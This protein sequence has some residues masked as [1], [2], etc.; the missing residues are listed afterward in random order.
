MGDS[1]E[2]SPRKRRRPSRL[3]FAAGALLSVVFAFFAALYGAEPRGLNP[4]IF[5][6]YQRIMPRDWSPDVP[7]RIA[8]IDSESIARYGQWPWPRTYFAEMVSR[9][10]ELGAAVIVFDIIFAEPDRTSPEILREMLQRFDTERA[11]TLAVTPFSSHDTAFARQIANAPVVLAMLPKSGAGEPPPFK[12]GIAIAGADPAAA[13]IG[14]GTADLPLALLVESAAGLG[15]A[16]VGD[17]R[18]VIVR[19]APMFVTIAGKIMPTLPAEA[20]RVAQGARSHLLKSSEGSG[21]GGTA[22][23]TGARIGAVEMPLSADGTMWI[24]YAG[25]QPGRRVPA[26]R[27]LEGAAPDPGLRG[28][29]EGQIVLVG[30]SAPGLR[31]LVATPMSEVTDG[32]TVHAE[33]I[34]QILLGSYL[35]RPDWAPPAEAVLTLL[36]CL[37]LT[38]IL[39]RHRPVLGTCFAAVSLL[40][41]G[42]GSWLAFADHNML[43]GPAWPSLGLVA[44]FGTLTLVNYFR[45]DVERQAVRQQ[46][47][48][49]VSP[50]VI[51]E[52][53]E[54]PEHHLSP[55]GELRELTIM[56]MDVRSF[57]TLSEKMA[58][59]TLIGFVNDFLGPLSEEILATG[60]TIDKYIGDAIMAFWNAPV[61]RPDHAVRAIEAALA[62]RRA[63][64]HFNPSF[65]QR[66][67]PEVAFGI[68]INTGPCAVGAMGSARRLDYSCIGDAVNLAS[69]LEGQTKTYGV[70]NCIGDR[71]AKLIDG[72]T[73]VEIDVVTVKGREGLEPLW[74]V[75]GDVSV[76]ERPEVRRLIT[77]IADTR[78]AIAEGNEAEA[79][80]LID[81]LPGLAVPELDPA[82]LA[83]IYQAQLTNR[84]TSA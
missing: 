54:D 66:G 27:L 60:G 23:V 44:T 65:V 74:T 63:A 42:S 57:S 80:S 75:L 82:R 41:I 58:P 5:D 55:G 84:Q 7:V 68:G 64:A 61:A 38:L 3:V 14:Y 6:S 53:M 47:E 59:D 34:E 19:R 73:A 76:G 16:G 72:Y 49:F 21:D 15:V 25:P 13:L 18:S 28:L 43:L 37:A 31:Y 71:T 40:L 62:M 4:R 78:E 20:L 26:W 46:F 29:F 12:A 39:S 36:L 77:A 35:Y 33:V 67:L 10:Q 79:I 69:R 17:G 30:A 51:A 11:P 70:W 52:I 9:L 45:S 22:V 56:F 50:D 48:R 32:V 1:T 83:E 2:A 8:D 81:A 24:R